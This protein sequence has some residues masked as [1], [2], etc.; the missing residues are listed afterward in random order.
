MTGSLCP[1]QIAQQEFEPVHAI[2]KDHV[3]RP[4]QQLPHI[5]GRKESVRRHL[6][7]ERAL[8]VAGGGNVKPELRVHRDRVA[9]HERQRRPGLCADLQVCARRQMGV[10]CGE[11]VKVW[12]TEHAERVGRIVKVVHWARPPLS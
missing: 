1:D 6:E 7:E 10:Q 12:H 8:A 3:H 9:T 11:E 4:S 5:F 2:Q